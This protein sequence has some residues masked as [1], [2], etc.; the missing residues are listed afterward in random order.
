MT[1]ATTLL[2]S[3]VPSQIPPPHQTYDATVDAHLASLRPDL[4]DPA[5]MAPSEGRIPTRPWAKALE[6]VGLDQKASRAEH[7]GS[8][9][10]LACP[11]GHNDRRLERFSCM[12][13]FCVDCARLMGLQ[14]SYRWGVA[15]AKYMQ[16]RPH[17]RLAYYQLHIAEVPR[18]RKQINRMLGRLLRKLP[19]NRSCWR[20]VRGYDPQ[21]RLIVRVMILMH[22]GDSMP[23][24]ET[25]FPDLD[26]KVSERVCRPIHQT[27]EWFDKLNEPIHIPSVTDR[28]AQELLFNKLHM[29]RASG[30]PLTAGEANVDLKNHYTLQQLSV[31]GLGDSDKFAD[32]TPHTVNMSQVVKRPCCAICERVMVPVTLWSAPNLKQVQIE[33][34][35][36]STRR[37]P[38]IH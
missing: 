7:C 30:P 1:S 8:V 13:H 31:D 28:A 25:W 16:R 33:A 26:I 34:L 10:V 19:R 18:V 2:H 27:P 9:R 17:D 22:D 21:G 11:A 12:C 38:L 15:V 35:I 24:P 36:A 29:F 6:A 14:V 4:L 3:S 5:L 20:S 23:V 37:A 32:A